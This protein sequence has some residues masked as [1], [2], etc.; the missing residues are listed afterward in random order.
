[1]EKTLTYF[2]IRHN[3]PAF[4]IEASK[5]FL[6]HYRAYY[7]L[8]VVEEFLKMVNIDFERGFELEPEAINELLYSDSYL[9]FDNGRV[10]L[11]LNDIKSSLYYIPFDLENKKLK[12]KS[13][14]PIVSLVKAKNYYKV[15]I[16]NKRVT[17]LYPDDFQIDES[18]N[19]VNMKIDGVRR[20]VKIGSVIDV[21]SSFLVESID[22]YRVNLIGFTKRNLIDESDVEVTRRDFISKYSIDRGERNFRVEIYRAGKFCGMIL[23]RFK[24]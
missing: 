9:S 16:G 15:Y 5:N 18:L 21:N 12:F 7:H 22:G 3:K 24:I 11:D 10:K 8:L 19:S 6:T 2:A 20:V 13:N 23:V 1:M 17:T 4:G 14:N